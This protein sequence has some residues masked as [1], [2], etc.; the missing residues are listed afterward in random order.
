MVLPI[1]PSQGSKQVIIK[2]TESK[3]GQIKRKMILFENG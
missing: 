3:E 2:V 1:N